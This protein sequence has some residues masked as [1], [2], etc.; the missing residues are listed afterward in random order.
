MTNLQQ[1]QP[2][3]SL[4][5][6]LVE[7]DDDHAKIIERSLRA[8]T[9]TQTS[10]TRLKDGVEAIRYIRQQAGYENVDRPDVVLLDLKLPKKNGH[11]VL[12][13]I[14]GDHELKK[15]PVVILTTS[16]AE[17]DKVKAYEHS[18]NSYLVKPL[19][20][21]AFQKMIQDLSFYW[22]VWNKG[23]QSIH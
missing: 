20:R 9:R 22:S 4:H 14:K 11:E 13:E 10:L 8:E 1:N 15:I 3:K 19:T 21:D 23:T 6:L 16:D 7:D 5:F 18:A 17:I 12:M 2:N